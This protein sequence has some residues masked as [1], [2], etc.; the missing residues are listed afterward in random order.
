VELEAGD[1]TIRLANIGNAGPNIDSLTVSR[2]G[3]APDR[4]VEPGDRFSVKINFQPEGTAVP[5]GYIADNGKAFGTQSVTVD[6]QTYQYGWVTEESIY[7]GD[8]GTE[9]LDISSLTSVAVNDRTDDIAGLDPRQGT[10]AHFDQPGP[11]YVRAG[12]EIEL[13]DGFYEVTISIGDTSGP[14]D[15]NNVLNAEGELFNARSNLAISLSNDL[16]NQYFIDASKGQLVQRL[17]VSPATP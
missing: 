13:E 9:P 2:D 11:N 17:G 10:Y 1:N 6:G 15:S 3:V 4:P 8:P 14:Y 16:V 5:D 12:W 7:D